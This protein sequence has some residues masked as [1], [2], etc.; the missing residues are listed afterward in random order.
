MIGCEGI[1]HAAPCY[2]EALIRV[3]GLRTQCLRSKDR[4]LAV[5]GVWSSFLFLL[6]HAQQPNVIA[7]RADAL[8]LRHHGS[9]LARTPDSA[10]VG[11]KGDGCELRPPDLLLEPP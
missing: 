9:L 2:C 8:R 11:V 7:Q 3:I 6:P 4:F 10:R 5:T 1:V